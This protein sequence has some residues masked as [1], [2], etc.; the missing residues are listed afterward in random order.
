L[1]YA[2]IFSQKQAKTSFLRTFADFSVKKFSFL[3]VLNKTQYIGE[4]EGL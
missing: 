4:E 2:K 3:H 1:N